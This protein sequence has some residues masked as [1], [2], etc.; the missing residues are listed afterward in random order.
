VDSP[1]WVKSRKE[2]PKNP[3][4]PKGP[5]TPIRTKLGK[6]FTGFTG[7]N[8]GENPKKPGGRNLLKIP[9]GGGRCPHGGK[10]YNG[11]VGEKFFSGEGGR[12][13]FFVI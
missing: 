7:G 13:L 9:G 6:Y 5:E 12:E 11:G 3:N 2:G 4:A 8:G 1:G 10:N